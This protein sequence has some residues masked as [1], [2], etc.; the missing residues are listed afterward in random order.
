MLFTSTENLKMDA[1]LDCLVLFTKLYHKPFSAEALTAGLPVE[2]GCDAPELFSIDNAKGLFSRAAEKAGLKSSLIKR[3]LSQISPLQLPMIILLSNQ[4]ACILDSFSKDA[5]MAKIVIPAEEAIEQWV[6]IDLL[7]DEYIGFGFMIKKAFEYSDKNSRTLHLDQKHWFWSTIKLS[8]PIYKDVLYAS[9]LINLFVLASPLFTM[10]VYDRVVP[11]NATETLWVFAIGVTVVYIIDTFLK[12]TRTYLLEVAA[13]KSDVI[14]SSIIFEKILDLKMAYHPA[15]VGSFASNI[16]DFDNIRSFLT[17]ATMTAVIDL[18]FTIIFLFV[19]GYI[20]GWIVLIPIIT[21]F[22]ITAY[23]LLIKKP[24]QESIESTHE[25]SAKKNSILIEALNNIETLKTLGAVNQ[26]QWNWEESTGEIA[27]RSLKSRLL[28]ASI[29]TVTQFF[30]QLNTVMIIIYGV[31]L[32]QDFELSLGGLIAIVILTARTLAPIGQVAALLTNYE[33][34]KTS[35]E[36]LN[37]IISQPSERP[38]GKKFLQ[39]PDFSGHIEFVDVTF[40]YPNSDV[41]A[42]K[43]VSFTIKPGEHVAIIGRI[44]SG[45]STIQKLILGLYEPDSGQI[46]IDGIDIKQIDPSDLRKN[47]GYVSQDIMLFRGTVKDNITFCASHA[48]D[49]SMIRAADISTTADFIKKHPKG[50]EMP[51]GERGQGLSGGQRQ[52]I[53]IARAFLLESPIM[54]LDEPSNAMDQTT[55]AKLLENML[56]ALNGRT[57]LIVTQKMTLLK[58][59]ERV[60]V[61]NEGKIFID[62]PKEEALAKL[63]GKQDAQGDNLEKK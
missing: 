2:A 21:M 16:K 13:K 47:I 7:R 25:A 48:S 11:N 51:I 28:S 42:L 39:R 36:T 63:Q 52:S 35:Y 58:I 26:V 22:F 32:I 57:S 9:L 46:L 37:E 54:L 50:Y 4:G 27:T 24:L 40:S 49:A 33:D 8:L 20:G 62:A 41:P 19:I 56:K 23:A 59:V 29:P 44:G 17:N 10:N 38:S 12:F 15:S 60:I 34:T 43:N 45:K 3:P 5:K 18:P 61:M 14:M 30:I 6:E 31:Y 1:L 55:E 53:G